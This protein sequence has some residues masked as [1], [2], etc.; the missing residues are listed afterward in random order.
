[1]AICEWSVAASSAA[2]MPP[3]TVPPMRSR[4]RR[5]VPETWGC[6]TMSEVR[7]QPVAVIDV[8]Q[9]DGWRRRGRR[10]GR[11]GRVAEG[12]GSLREVA[13]RASRRQPWRN[14]ARRPMT[15]PKW[16][17]DAPGGGS[18]GSAELPRRSTAAA[19]R[20]DSSSEAA[21]AIW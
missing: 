5:R 3:P 2:R 21:W 10:P 8:E 13:V 4:P 12:E 16:L 1:M 20:E 7:E 19:S 14:P 6:R 11:R 17:A 9:K 18:S 15:Y